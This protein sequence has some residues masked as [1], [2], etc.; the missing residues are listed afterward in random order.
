MLLTDQGKREFLNSN[1]HQY[2]DISLITNI[3]DGVMEQTVN[4]T[5]SLED[6][7]EMIDLESFKE[8]Y[9][10]EGY[11]NVIF[12]PADNN[13]DIYDYEFYG[14]VYFIKMRPFA[15]EIRMHILPK[16]YDASNRLSN[17]PVLIFKEKLETI[18][19]DNF[20][21]TDN[22]E[23]RDTPNPVNLYSLSDSDESMNNDSGIYMFDI[24]K[25]TKNFNCLQINLGYSYNDTSSPNHN[26]HFTGVV[27]HSNEY[28]ET[29]NPNEFT[30]FNLS[31][32]DANSDS[33]L[34][35]TNKIL[36]Q[37]K[38]N[39]GIDW[40]NV[41]EH[42][43]GFDVDDG[44]HLLNK[45]YHKTLKYFNDDLYIEEEGKYH[46]VDWIENRGD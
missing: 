34:D 16:K 28:G 44:R 13:T 45:K 12:T 40:N 35:K 8:L 36:Q 19:E 25:Y 30:E 41:Y 14:G 32:M 22:Y 2:F 39:N 29:I 46:I 18:N 27:D 21:C 6:I 9:L 20:E 33:I 4:L 26:W 23:R 42:S 17:S 11:N 37:H 31:L 24:K 15:K 3:E 38:T 43:G 5:L 1:F 7:G 10:N